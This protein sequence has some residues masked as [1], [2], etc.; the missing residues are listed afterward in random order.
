MMAER[1]TIINVLHTENRE[2]R[3]KRYLVIMT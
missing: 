3:D 1:T 2:K